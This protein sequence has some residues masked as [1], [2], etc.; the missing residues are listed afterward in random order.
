[1]RQVEA[2]RNCTSLG[3]RFR[4]HFQFQRFVPCLHV[5]YDPLIS[6]RNYP[7]FSASKYNF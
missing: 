2:E 6:A 1:M 3:L 7:T 4:H 5:A